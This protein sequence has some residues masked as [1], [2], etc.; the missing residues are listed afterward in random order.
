MVMSWTVAV[1]L[2]NDHAIV[3]TEIAVVADVSNVAATEIAAVVDE[4]TM[5]VAVVEVV[6]SSVK[7]TFGAPIN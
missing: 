3:A 4:T 5:I 7:S 1:L 2:L 6:E